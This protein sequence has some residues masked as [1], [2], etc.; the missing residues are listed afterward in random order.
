MKR[1]TGLVRE[2]ELIQ[3]KIALLRRE[4]ARIDG[5]ISNLIATHN[6]KMMVLVE[7]TVER[8]DLSQVRVQTLVS[9]LSKVSEAVVNDGPSS[10][11]T[12]NIQAFVR[13]GRNASASNR[14]RLEAAGLHWN[15]RE[16]GWVG[17][18]TEAQLADLH[19]TFGARVEK[20]KL[21]RA[22]EDLGEP[23]KD[24]QGALS[25][26]VE[27]I[28]TPAEEEQGQAGAAGLEEPF[29]ATTLRPSS[30]GFPTRRTTM[31]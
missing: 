8:W 25:A 11:A 4:Q 31:T 19:R 29:N 14:E 26:D 17:K 16:G 15:G 5:E 27:A 22:G 30:F 3:A 20:P 23:L 6:A 1:H 13:F 18:T 24:A 7:A 2:I 12:A 28:A 21:V 10:T 9:S